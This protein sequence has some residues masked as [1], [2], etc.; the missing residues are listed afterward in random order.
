MY[1]YLII[2]CN[3]EQIFGKSGDCFYRWKFGQSLTFIQGKE[4]SVSKGQFSLD[5]Y[6]C[7]FP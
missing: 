2:N 7:I 1:N 5:T 4:N 6:Y 3:K